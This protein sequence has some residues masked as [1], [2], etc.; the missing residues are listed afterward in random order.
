ME[1]GDGAG[2]DI[3]SF[4]NRDGVYERIY[5]EVKGTDKNYT[6]PF[7]VSINEITVS[8]KYKENYYIYR[9]AKANTKKPIFYK[10]KGSIADNFELTPVKFKAV[11]KFLDE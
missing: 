7:D 4:E 11:R 8:E 10:I 3:E 2:Y 6:E 5:I 9:I 1:I